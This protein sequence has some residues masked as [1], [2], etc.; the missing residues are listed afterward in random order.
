MVPPGPCVCLTGTA[1]NYFVR[2]R[3]RSNAPECS[4]HDLAGHGR[5]YRGGRGVRVQLRI[6]SHNCSSRLSQ[7]GGLGQFEKACPLDSYFER[8][9]RANGRH[10]WVTAGH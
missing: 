3:S 9:G 2:V 5:P 4:D 7:P 10:D 8:R 1:T 6:I